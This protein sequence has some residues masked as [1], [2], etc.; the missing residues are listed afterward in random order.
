VDVNFRC[1]KT[2]LTCP[3]LGCA[4]FLNNGWGLKY[5]TK[6]G[7]WELIGTVRAPAVL[8][9]KDR[10]QGVVVNQSEP[11]PNQSRVDTPVF[12]LER[13]QASPTKTGCFPPLGFQWSLWNDF[14][15]RCFVNKRE[16]LISLHLVVKVSSVRVHKFTPGTSLCSGRG[17]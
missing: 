16:Q 4:S 5:S 9:W 14:P 2:T 10:G 11:T 12:P 17:G 1:M 7:Q 3:V 6:G 8:H 15:S 13:F